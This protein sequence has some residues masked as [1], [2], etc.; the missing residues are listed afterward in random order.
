MLLHRVAKTD[1]ID[2]SKTVFFGDFASL[3]ASNAVQ[4]LARIL[5]RRSGQYGHWGK[6]CPQNAAIVPN[7]R[8]RRFAS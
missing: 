3:A 6:F 8:G 7:D 5:R 2:R 1:I 4:Q